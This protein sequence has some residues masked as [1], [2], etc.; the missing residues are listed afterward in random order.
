[1]LIVGKAAV[2]LKLS[3]L[4]D[5]DSSEERKIQITSPKCHT[6]WVESGRTITED[7]R[8]FIVY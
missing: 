7:E 2:L 4:G 3:V 5:A 1:M 8:M 6:V